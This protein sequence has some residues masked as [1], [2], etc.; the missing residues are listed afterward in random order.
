MIINDLAI[1]WYIVFDNRL[2]E[3]QTRLKSSLI[4]LLTKRFELSL[5]FGLKRMECII[6][7]SVSDKSTET[8]LPKIDFQ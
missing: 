3:F 1:S 5:P 7:L 6:A 4:Y 8:F 2:E